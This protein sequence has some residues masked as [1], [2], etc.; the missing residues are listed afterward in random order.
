M[1]YTADHKQQT[2]AGIVEAASGLFKR[3]GYVGV[4]VDA[5][6]KAAGLTAGG[7]YA[8]F[9]SKEALFTETFALAVKRMKEW[10]LAGL[11]DREGLPWLREIVRRYLSRV[12][13]DAVAEGCPLPAL[14]PDVFRSGDVVRE[15]F[16]A[17]FRQVVAALE[18]KMPATLGSRYDRALAT[19]ALFVGGVMLARAV[20]DRNLSG[21]ILRACRLLAI[22][23]DAPYAPPR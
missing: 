20:K 4:G 21:R 5:V 19:L 10:L 7:F 23:E 1:R 3:G 6:M 2:H 8:H 17:Q 16:E 11:E 14:S 15:T 9:A 13:R 12:H 18:Q 22:P